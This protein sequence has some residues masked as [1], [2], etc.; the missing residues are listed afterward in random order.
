MAD[1]TL[2]AGGL[3]SSV[4]TTDANASTL[5]KNMLRQNNIDPDLYTNQELLDKSMTLIKSYIQSSATAY[6]KTAAAEAA[7]E[8]TPDETWNGS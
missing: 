5:L 1:I 2:T 6:A 3:S 8:A 7:R 4:T